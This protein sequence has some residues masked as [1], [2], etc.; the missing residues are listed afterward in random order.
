MRQEV[1]KVLGHPKA[2]EIFG[3]LFMALAIL[4]LASL[5]SFDASDPSF[6][7][8]RGS[9]TGQVKNLA[10]NLGAHLAGDLF[11]LL[12]ISSF[13][14]PFTFFLLGWFIFWRKGLPYWGL[15][16]SGLV[17]FLVCL[18]LLSSLLWAGIQ[19]NGFR[20]DRSG[21]LWGRVGRSAV[22]L[23][24]KV[25]PLSGD[26]DRDARFPDPPLPA[27]LAPAGL[28]LRGGDGPD[29]GPAHRAVGEAEEEDR[30]AS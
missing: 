2:R 22:T 18:S 21:G 13:L 16:L 20:L 11:E 9:M 27:I 17:L 3:I 1:L 14:L 5:I 8:Y 29:E 15:K 19:L 10:G 25:W 28:L 26:L 6:F 7:H 30:E 24:G 23:S 12:G 4:L